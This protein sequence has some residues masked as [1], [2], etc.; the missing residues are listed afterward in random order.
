MTDPDLSSAAPAGADDNL[1]DEAAA[2]GLEARPRG[3]TQLEDVIADASFPDVDL[4]LRRGRHIHKGDE[5]WY[6]FLLEAQG[7]LETFYRRYG[8][9]LEQRTDGYFFLLPLTDSLG[10]RHLGVA[11][12]IVGQGLALCYLDPA[13]VQS[14]GVVTREELLN[15]LAAVMGTDALMR[16]LNPKRKRVDERVMQ[17]TVRSKVNDAL[18]RLGQLG[19]VELLDAERLQLRP[20][21]MRFAEPVRGLD[22]PS[23]A[24]KRLIERGEISMGPGDADAEEASDGELDP[25]ADDDAVEAEPEAETAAAETAAPE[26]SETGNADPEWDETPAVSGDPASELEALGVPP[27]AEPLG[28]NDH[29]PLGTNDPDEP[30]SDELDRDDPDPKLRSPV[31]A[32]P[33][34]VAALPEIDFEWDS[35]PEPE[36]DPKELDA[37]APPGE[38]A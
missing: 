36:P 38:E 17:R 11:E 23:E 34:P 18:R 2:P 30:G 5:H 20:S 9:E 14:G 22:A 21:L 6:D 4:A 8:C 16:T 15:Q 1:P 25:D 31:S 27:E 28:T 7:H 10:K 12:M 19:F 3:F 32:A 35:M 26:T 24:L 13:S 37:E 29:E 33:D